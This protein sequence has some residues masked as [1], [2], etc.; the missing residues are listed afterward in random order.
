MK[1]DKETSNLWKIF[2]ELTL[3]LIVVKMIYSVNFPNNKGY[4]NN[5]G[6]YKLFDFFLGVDYKNYSAEPCPLH[7]MVKL[8]MRIPRK[9]R[10]C[11]DL[12]QKQ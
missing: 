12:S 7:G 10:S 4:T 9:K 1:N 8:T 11:L 2:I 6:V 5:N 3:I